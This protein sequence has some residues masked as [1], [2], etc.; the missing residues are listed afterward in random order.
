MR[1]SSLVFLCVFGL[2]FARS[3]HAGTPFRVHFDH[4]GSGHSQAHSHGQSRESRASHTPASKLSRAIETDLKATE[5]RYRDTDDAV[6]SLERSL[7]S[8]QDLVR[9][10]ERDLQRTRRDRHFSE[11]VRIREET[12]VRLSAD[13]TEVAKGHQ[14][15]IALREMLKGNRTILQAKLQLARVGQLESYRGV[16]AERPA[17]TRQAPEHRPSPLDALGEGQEVEF[18]Y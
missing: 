4:H 14:N 18:S 13:L 8:L 15:L 16:N 11:A 10:A 3:R 9:T 1:A 7:R 17:L 12:M 5:Q 6:R 2:L